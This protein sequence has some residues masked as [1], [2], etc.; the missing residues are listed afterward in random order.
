[1]GS[2]R[3][4]K[5]IF[6]ILLLITLGEL[7]Y[8]VYIQFNREKYVQ[9]DSSATLKISQYSKDNL[10]NA[11]QTSAKQF[12]DRYRPNDSQKFTIVV[13]QYGY[14]K[15]IKYGPNS[16][17]PSYI[18]LGDEDGNIISEY[19]ID[20]DTLFAKQLG[21]NPAVTPTGYQMGPKKFTGEKVSIDPKD[22]KIGWRIFVNDQ[23]EL[24]NL[25]NKLTR[26]IIYE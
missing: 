9:K 8:Y 4:L 1:M 17:S 13:E 24:P 5:I 25:N 6:V 19:L 23:V 12:I 20:K 3:L 15:D 7:G 18:I 11:V 2:Y 16:K 26:F 10:Y 22:L 14:I 21:N